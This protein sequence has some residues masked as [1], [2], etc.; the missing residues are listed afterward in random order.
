MSRARSGRF[1]FFQKPLQNPDPIRVSRRL[2]PAYPVD[3]RETQRDAGLVPARPV[4][5][6]E[7]DLQNQAFVARIFDFAHR[8]EAVDRMS[9]DVAIEL[10]Q[11][12]VGNAGL[13]LADRHQLFAVFTVPPDA[14]SIVGVKR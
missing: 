14:N 3:A 4:D 10:R 9:A 2:V 8:A 5:A 11:L 1:A 6:F 7:R 13:G 12:F